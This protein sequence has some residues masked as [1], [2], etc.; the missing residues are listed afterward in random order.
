MASVPATAAD[1]LDQLP[2]IEAVICP[3]SRYDHLDIGSAATRHDRYFLT[4][5]GGATP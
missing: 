5:L 1:Q 2:P 4:P 3:T